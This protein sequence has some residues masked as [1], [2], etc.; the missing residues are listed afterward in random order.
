[1]NG[2]KRNH[3]DIK[4]QNITPRLG[5]KIK[6]KNQ[7]AVLHQLRNIVLTTQCFLFSLTINFSLMHGPCGH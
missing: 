4:M 7:A 6:N 2:T 5:E 3:K 1:V